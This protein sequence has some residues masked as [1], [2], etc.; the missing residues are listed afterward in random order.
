MF[1]SLSMAQPRVPGVWPA[2]LQYV[3]RY[4]AWLVAAIAL[5]GMAGWL[6][7]FPGLTSFG[8]DFPPILPSSIVS[9]MA[10]AAGLSA[11]QGSFG[12]WR[13]QVA[14]AAA[15]VI[16]AI[17]LLSLAERMDGISLGMDFSLAHLGFPISLTMSVAGSCT[18]LLLATAL[19]FASS[20]EPRAGS[21]TR[22][23]AI[24]IA[25]AALLALVGLIF[26]II[27]QDD[28]VPPM[29]MAFPTALALLASSISLGAMRPEKRLLQ[30]LEHDSPGATIF[31]RLLPA[32]LVLPILVGWMEAVG[33]RY[34]W[35]DIAA[36]EGMATVAMVVVCTALIWWTSSKLDDMNVRRSL[37][38]TR[39]DTQ[40]EWLEVTLANIG[41]AVIAAN[42]EGR[43][44][45]MNPATESLCGIEPAS[46]VG[47]PVTE[48]LDL[49]DERTQSP[50][51]CPLQ[52]AF[53]R[54]QPVT[55]EGE[56]AI[57]LPD[58][59][60]QAVDVCAMPILGGGGSLLGGI[61]VLRDARESRAREKAMRN[62]YTELDRRVGERTLALER[63][64]A[65]LRE[66]TALLQTIAASTPELIVAKDRDCRIMMINPAALEALG[67]AR[68]RVVGHREIEIFGESEQTRRMLASDQEVM[69]TGKA[70]SVEETIA[71]SAGTRTFLV[72]KSPLRAEDGLLLG[73]VSVATDI[74]ERKRAQWELEQ[75]L[76]AEHKLRGDAERASRAK[77]EFLAI[78]SHEL[79]SPL[80]AL[81]GWSQM[82][83]SAA[84]PDPDL[85]ARAAQA[86]KRNVEHQT[87]LIDD[88]LD[89]SRIIIGKLVLER[90]PVNLADVVHAALDLSRAS[91]KA[92][93]IELRFSSDRPEMVVDGDPGRLQQVVI[94]LL[95]NGIKFTPHGGTVE[96]G[97]RQAEGRVQLTVAD[98]GIGIESDFLPY[99]FDRFSQADSST[100][101]RYSGL[102]IGLALV[103]HL[104]EM[105]GGTVR[106]SSPGPGQG[107]A[108]TIDLPATMDTAGSG[109]PK[110]GGE[111]RSL[112][113]DG[114][115]GIRILVVD[116]E[117]DA[118]EVMQFNLVR[119]GGQVQ[120]FESGRALLALLRSDP[121][122]VAA[123]PTV[124]LLD[125]AM[126]GEDGFGVLS[127]VRA[128]RNL[129][130]IPAIAVTALTHLDRDGLAAAGFQGCLGKP[131]EPAKLVEGILAVVEKAFY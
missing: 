99:V 11:L 86:I 28:A 120:V 92:K 44:G 93:E 100:T 38:E 31:R 59:R 110:P 57:R 88:L 72:T 105:H 56:P 101:R 97:L 2:R 82:L 26:R 106:V 127:E 12:P 71:T 10:A 19:A 123:M 13:R 63:A 102:G 55:A 29:D 48:L 76:L 18:F 27:R 67:L 35:F 125:I 23:A 33:Q 81:K 85:A 24:V 121:A 43:V 74:T 4:S 42:D 39:A 77:D 15:L 46:A 53:I 49:V 45:F 34:G 79:R 96:V 52:E 54:R 37:A 3:A 104:V 36:G 116:D 98:N 61:L 40:R 17:A 9:L 66:S 7:G 80:N 47:R 16:A 50:L 25:G 107:T 8:T 1:F 95:S 109:G 22:R 131:V 21:V 130:S 90:R 83:T 114:L 78:V 128:I 124:L 84:N 87:R 14:R 73:L 5:A 58:G 118:R 94:N 117:A 115:Q 75:L 32:A 129:P 30:L 108:F 60:L 68:E 64:A 65:A 119:A 62:A 6:G 126:P 122:A 41:D 111:G 103:R 51:A 91:A 113:Q 112:P 69:E 70:M 89:T 20:D